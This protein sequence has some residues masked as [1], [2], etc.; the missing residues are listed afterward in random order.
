MSAKP[1]LTTS[2]DDGYPSDVRVG[3]LLAKYGLQG[4]FYVPVESPWARLDNG[5]V[6]AL[7]EAF[8][9]GA[10]TVHHVDLSKLSERTAETE[11]RA[12]KGIWEKLT[13]KP[14]LMF[15][16]PR[17]RYK[18]GQLRLVQEAGFIGARTVELMSLD[19]PRMQDGVLVMPTTMQANTHSREAYVRNMGKRMAVRNFLNYVRHPQR[20]WVAAAH[21][22]LQQAVRSRGVFHLWGHSGEIDIHD[23]WKELEELFQEM[24][25]WKASAPCVNNSEVCNHATAHRAA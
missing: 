21:G 13:G 3:D 19:F 10:H 16:F 8:E 7:S 11:I 6:K 12:P 17:G 22:L 25:R 9:I 1:L 18:Q 14:C 2:W 15:C 23:R 24:A 4:T 5:A 20:D